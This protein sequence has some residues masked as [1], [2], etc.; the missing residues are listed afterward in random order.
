MVLNNK[1]YFGSDDKNFY[2]YDPNYYNLGQINNNFD[3]VI[4]N[5]LNYLNPELD[6]SQLEIINKTNNSAIVKEKIIVINIFLKII[7]YII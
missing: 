5:E 4:L 7:K 1:I 2:E 6:I 3:S